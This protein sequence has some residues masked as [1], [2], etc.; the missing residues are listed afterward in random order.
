[1]GVHTHTL[2]TPQHVEVEVIASAHRVTRCTAV[3]TPAQLLLPQRE[4]DMG[5][6]A[7]Y[8]TR[9][10]CGGSITRVVCVCVCVCVCAALL[11]GPLNHTATVRYATSTPDQ[12]HHTPLPPPPHAVPIFFQEERELS[13]S[14]V[15]VVGILGCDERAVRL[16]VKDKRARERER[17]VLR[18]QQ[19]L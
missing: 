19:H 16:S 1:V 3:A 13:L 18:G 7:L 9:C 14:A 10:L 6:R 17:G 15:T 11:R 4:R 8:T 5:M 12:D 2:S